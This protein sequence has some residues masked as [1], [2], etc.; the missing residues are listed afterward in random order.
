MYKCNSLILQ[1]L[2]GAQLPHNAAPATYNGI[3]VEP[4]PRVVL[5]PS[6]ATLLSD[7]KVRAEARRQGEHKRNGCLSK[8]RSSSESVSSCLSF[9]PLLQPTN[10]AVCADQGCP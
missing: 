9:S 3:V 2:A 4:F 7:V 5:S 10:A 8:L 1:Q 6:F